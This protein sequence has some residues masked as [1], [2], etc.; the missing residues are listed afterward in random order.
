M[1]NSKLLIS[2]FSTILFAFNAIPAT[3][4]T[5]TSNI[6]QIG[7]NKIANFGEA[8]D[9]SDLTTGSAL[10]IV[11]PYF[12][13]VWYADLYDWVKKDIDNGYASQSMRQNAYFRVC[14]KPPPAEAGG[15]MQHKVAGCP[16]KVGFVHF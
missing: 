9:R 3:A 13:N 16:L 7:S 2:L 4:A 8:K 14:N 15:F 6:T 11:E 5:P 1:K 12:D 10:E